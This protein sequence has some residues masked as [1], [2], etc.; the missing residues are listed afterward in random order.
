[1]KSNNNSFLKILVVFI[2]VVAI[3]YLFQAG[4]QTGNWLYNVLH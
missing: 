2:I 3:I 4:Y 1:M